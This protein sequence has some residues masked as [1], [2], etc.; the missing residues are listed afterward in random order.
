ML[1]RNILVKVVLVKVSVLGA[2]HQ[3]QASFF[4]IE[5]YGH[6]SELFLI[7]WASF[8][9][10]DV[11]SGGLGWYQRIIDSNIDNKMNKLTLREFHTCVIIHGVNSLA[12]ML[13]L[14]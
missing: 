12:S 13:V 1:T 11:K 8:L 14:G 7:A 4:P 2:R 3:D 10:F 5:L 9:K 6:F